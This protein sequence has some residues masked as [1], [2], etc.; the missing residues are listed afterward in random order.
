MFVVL[1]SELFAQNNH[2]IRLKRH[3]NHLKIKTKK[4]STLKSLKFCINFIEIRDIF[5][6]INNNKK[7]FSS[8]VSTTKSSWI[9]HEERDGR[10]RKPRFILHT[11]KTSFIHKNKILKINPKEKQNE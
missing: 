2:F 9:V 1:R 11:K 5:F 7:E 8:K 3:E 4:F 6:E 10:T